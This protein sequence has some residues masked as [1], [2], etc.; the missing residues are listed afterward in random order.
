MHTT[1]ALGLLAVL[2]AGGASADVPPATPPPPPVT[3]SVD[4]TP[5]AVLVMPPESEAASTE[6]NWV[7]ELV[8]ELLPRGLQALG[9]PAVDRADRLRAQAALEIPV[10][11]LTRATSIRV[12]EAL[13]ARRLVFGT[14]VVR[15]SMI[16]LTLRV[17][18]VGRAGT[19]SPV[20]VSAPLRGVGDLAQGVAW[21]V[22]GALGRAPAVSREQFAARRPG[23]PFEAMEALGKALV[24]QRPPTQTK[25]LRHALRLAPDLAEARLALGR[26]QVETGEYSAAHGTLA[27][28]P[29]SAPVSRSARFLRGVSEL[30]IGRYAD[31]SAT[32]ATL[33]AERPTPA[34]LNNQALAVLRDPRAQLRASDLLR[35]A[36]EQAPD[37]GDVAFNLGWAL[38]FENDPAAAEFFL[39]GLVRRDPLEGHARVVLSW[40]L[41]KAGRAE[42]AAKEW[43][44]VLAMAPTYSTLGAPDLGRRFERIL[45]SE[46]L[47]PDARA[48]R[49]ESEVAAGLVGRAERRLAAG[50][51]PG[52]LRDLERAA[53]LDPY[54]QKVHLLLARAHRAQGDRER[55][56]N[57]LRM[58]LWSQDDPAIRA[59]MAQLLMEMGR[60]DEA[61]QEAEKVLKLD[62]G[63]ELARKVA[64][65]G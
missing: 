1:L 59:E 35:R 47:R 19:A 13:G 22:A 25:L 18:D 23:G 50:D 60:R 7:G 6:P 40:A 63:N 57:E 44:G 42:E 20:V 46:R 36:L 27:R 8:S 45:P 39:R 32:Y 15:D 26:V 5:E 9:V 31:A 28:I 10:V 3:S 4:T 41:R 61:R 33:A 34:V 58:T 11:P 52:A 37:S 53:Y 21:D 16:T 64:G 56:L 48:E 43:Q 62:P 54:A 30:H 49:S 51:A 14:Y 38:L 55:A 12:A 65:G 17:L 24:S 29:A 2:G